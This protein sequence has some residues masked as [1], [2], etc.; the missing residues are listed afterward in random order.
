MEAADSFRAVALIYNYMASHFKNIV[1]S[2]ENRF[3]YLY[4]HAAQNFLSFYL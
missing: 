2:T 4:V 1:T 3:L